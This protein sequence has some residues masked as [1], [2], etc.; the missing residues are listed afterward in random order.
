M[1]KWGLYSCSRFRGGNG[2]DA[3]ALFSSL[4]KAFASLLPSIVDV[5]VR[6]IHKEMAAGG[7]PLRKVWLLA[8]RRK[9]DCS[10]L[11]SAKTRG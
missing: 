7:V 5:A 6:V 3:V 8:P 1:R 9:S 4:G 11:T 2:P 10:Q